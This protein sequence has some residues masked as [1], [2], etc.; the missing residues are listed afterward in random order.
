MHKRKKNR[1]IFLIFV[2]AISLSSLSFIIANFKENIIF[3][4]SPSDLKGVT[5]KGEI[6]RLGGLVE[7]NSIKKPSSNQIEFILIDNNAKILVKYQ[8]I[9]PDLFREDQ[10]M[11]A[12]G[13]LQ[14]GVFVAKELLVKHDENYM[15]PEVYKTLK[16]NKNSSY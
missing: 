6:F 15:P 13:V 14:N 11:I 10:G 3:F 2:F 4:Y 7:K 16:K 9:L 1:I 5:D 8:G 12:K